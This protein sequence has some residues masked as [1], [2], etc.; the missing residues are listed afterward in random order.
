[1]VLIGIV[2]KKYS[3]K[4]T[5]ASH[6]VEHHRFVEFAF[7][8]PLKSVCMEAF[9]FSH[10]QLYGSMLEK[11]SVDP[12]WGISPRQALQDVGKMFRDLYKVRPQY[13]Q[14]WVRVVERS[15]SRLDSTW[16][17]V[18]SDVRY[19]DEANMI[20]KRGGILIGVYRS[21]LMTTDHHE[22]ENQD[23]QVN[24][25]IRNDGSIDDLKRKVDEVVERLYK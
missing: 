12:Y 21:D 17:I 16:N 4:S 5:I 3:G 9:G 7:A 11:E 6:L 2:G 22:S 13:N 25:V 23:I 18:V 14:I 15:L 24:I 8:T 1:M 10:K 20:R 19:K